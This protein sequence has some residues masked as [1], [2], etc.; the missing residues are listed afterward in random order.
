M[1]GRK[2]SEGEAGEWTLELKELE[3]V[4]RKVDRG[5]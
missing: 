3:E 5:I 1:R 4:H 2:R